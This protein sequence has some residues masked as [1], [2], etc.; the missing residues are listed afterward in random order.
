[1]L[2]TKQI[3]YFGILIIWKSDQKQHKDAH[4]EKA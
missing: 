4:M 3:L 1:M 2:P